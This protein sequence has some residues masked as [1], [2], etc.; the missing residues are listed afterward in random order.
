M[1]YSETDA[2]V[3]IDLPADAPIQLF[4]LKSQQALIRPALEQRW[5]GYR[6]TVA[7]A[8]GH[9]A[10]ASAQLATAAP[11]LPTVFSAG[12]DPGVALSELASLPIDEAALALRQWLRGCQLP[13]PDQ[14]PLLEG[15]GARMD[16][17]RVRDDARGVRGSV[18]RLVREPRLARGAAV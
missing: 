7:R 13:M 2:S 5:P 18:H 8:A 16:E 15:L 9:L 10:T 3:L 4:D 11:T 12:G 1:A 17:L 14:A 6:R